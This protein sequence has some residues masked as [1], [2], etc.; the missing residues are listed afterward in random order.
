MVKRGAEPEAQEKIDYAYL[1]SKGDKDFIYT[2]TI[3]NDQ[4]TIN[5]KHGLSYYC[6][7]TKTMETDWGM[8]ISK[9][10]HRD[11]VEDPRFFTDWRWHI[12]QAWDLYSGG[13]RFYGYD[14]RWK[15]KEKFD[16]VYAENGN[17]KL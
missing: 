6:P 10:W 2:L 15:A 4:W 17:N 8:G 13:T 9:C 7:L 1:I 11:K 12:E 3:E 14:I 5:R 16:I